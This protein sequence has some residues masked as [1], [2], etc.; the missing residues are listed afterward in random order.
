MKCANHLERTALG[1]CAQCGKALCTACLVRLPTGNYCEAC[2]TAE[3]RAIRGRRGIPWW[4]VGLLVL[5]A[6]ILVR[7]FFH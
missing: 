5:A 7:T 2:A 6:L 3:P 1:Y 4:A